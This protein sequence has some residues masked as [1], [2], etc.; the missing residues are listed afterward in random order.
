MTPHILNLARKMGGTDVPPYDYGAKP[1]SMI[2]SYKAL[3]NFFNE[4]RNIGI[5]AGFKVCEKIVESSPDLEQALV[6]IRLNKG[7]EI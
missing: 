7:H 1:D 4:A 2:F 5:A 6:L 3:E